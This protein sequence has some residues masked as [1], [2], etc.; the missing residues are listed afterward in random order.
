MLLSLHFNTYQEC[1]PIGHV[2]TCAS[3]HSLSIS[4]QREFHHQPSISLAR[5][6]F[7]PPEHLIIQRPCHSTGHVI[8]CGFHHPPSMSSHQA[9]HLTLRISSSAEHVISICASDHPPSMSSHSADLIT[10]RACH[11]ILHIS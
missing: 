1:H 7:I 8:N 10:Q 2:I 11:P 5:G 4:C 6:P 3:N 9:Y